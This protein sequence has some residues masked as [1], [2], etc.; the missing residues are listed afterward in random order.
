MG[1]P[2]QALP[3]SPQSAPPLPSGDGVA[4]RREVLSQ[5][6][7]SDTCLTLPLSP[8]A[9]EGCLPGLLPFRPWSP[10][11]PASSPPASVPVSASAVALTP[12]PHSARSYPSPN[13]SPRM[14]QAWSLLAA[15]LTTVLV[16]APL[17]TPAL[18]LPRALGPAAS[19]PR[20][21]GQQPCPLWQAPAW[22]LGTQP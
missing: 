7:R 9:G 3:G 4:R 17:P 15:T 2:C 13:L 1:R 5:G 22:A 11:T 8:R 12:V 21:S 18:P 10:E 20:P 6:S 19:R 14:S 16:S